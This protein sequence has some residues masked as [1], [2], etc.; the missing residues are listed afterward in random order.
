MDLRRLLGAAA[1]APSTSVNE[2]RTLQQQGALLIDVRER[3]EWAGG[4]VPGA[5]HIPL[6]QL[7]QAARA[8]PGDRD[9]L[10]IC[11]SGN[12]SARA[13]ELLQRAGF[14]RATNVAGGMSA[15]S[16][17]GLPVTR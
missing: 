7:P 11:Q 12:R 4:H 2:A 16:R 10:L 15:W 3:R 9:L 13:T 14:S 17:A 8:L 1:A 6:G 5:R